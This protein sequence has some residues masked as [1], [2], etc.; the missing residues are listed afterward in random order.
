MQPAISKM[1]IDMYSMYIYTCTYAHICI[2]ESYKCVHY[3]EVILV[4]EQQ[5]LY[6]LS[7]MC[8]ALY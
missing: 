7:P 6:M 1:S 2:K 3:I 4:L 8:R 5:L